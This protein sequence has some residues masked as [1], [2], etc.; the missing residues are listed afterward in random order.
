MKVNILLNAEHIPGK[1]NILPDLLSR[2][3]IEK[4][5]ASAP[6]MDKVPTAI[7]GHLLLLN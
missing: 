3:Q 4:F 2:S 6:Q 5:Q 7:P 1:R